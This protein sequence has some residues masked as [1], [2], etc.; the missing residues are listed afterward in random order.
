MEYFFS[1]LLGIVAGYVASYCFL[2]SFL[3]YKKP[4]IVISPHISIDEFKGEKNYFFKFVN[5][6]KSNIYDVR[7]ETTLYKPIGDLKGRNLHGADIELKDNY[8]MYISAESS[9]DEHNLHVMRVRT[10][11][12]IEGQWVDGSSFIRLTVIAKHSLSGLNQVFH[13]DFNNIACITNKKFVSGND[14]GVV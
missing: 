7:I 13:Q 14:L 11:Q 6:T 12:D 10:T 3:Y 2:T 4:R 1:L 8:F 9:G 5:K